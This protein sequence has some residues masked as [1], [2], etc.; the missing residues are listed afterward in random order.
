MCGCTGNC[1]RKKTGKGIEM[2]N[3]KLLSGVLA[4]ILLLGLTACGK[5]PAEL[6]YLKDF[7]VDKY[8]TLGEYKGLSTTIA[9]PEEITEEDID[10]AIQTSALSDACVQPVEGRNVVENGDIANIDF[11]GTMDGEAFEGGTGADYDLV[12]GSGSFVP[13]FEEGVE[14]MKVGETKDVALTFPEN[15]YEDM[16]GKDVVFAVT[17]NSISTYDREKAREELWEQALENY[18]SQVAYELLDIIQADAR[19]KDAPSGMVD[20]MNQ[21]LLNNITTQAA[22]YGMDT[23]SFVAAVYGGTAQEYEDTLYTYSQNVANQYL[24]MA[25]IA[26]KEKITVTDEEVTEDIRAT[27]G[28]NATDADVESAMSSVDAEAY[29][30][31]LLTMKICDFLAENAVKAE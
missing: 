28:E 18:N 25:A 22:M 23:G 11:V 14:G 13:G 5:D 19:L 4:G 21:T 9:Y 8:V 20:R 1:F 27:L 3:K 26:Q 30:E 29:K 17:V 24:I 6:V 10:A 12:I 2:K 7:K 15:Y 31:Y 16:A